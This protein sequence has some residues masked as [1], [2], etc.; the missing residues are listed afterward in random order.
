M[1]FQDLEFFLL[2]GLYLSVG[3]MMPSHQVLRINWFCW[4]VAEGLQPLQELVF[5]TAAGVYRF[6]A[7]FPSCI[8]GF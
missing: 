8:V 5:W 1:Q 6:R 4:V 3:L 7:V 2:L